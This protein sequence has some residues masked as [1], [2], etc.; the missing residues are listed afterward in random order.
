[1]LSKISWFTEDP[2][3]DNK[4]KLATICNWVSE[5]KEEGLEWGEEQRGTLSRK[6][7]CNGLARNL[8][9]ENNTFSFSVS[10]SGKQYDRH[11]PVKGLELIENQPGIFTLMVFHYDTS[12][13][14]PYF[15]KYELH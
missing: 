4:E 14:Y 11:L 5:L 13:P 7:F 6:H 15:F 12:I 8:H 3:L 10:S 2:E 9:F 1:M